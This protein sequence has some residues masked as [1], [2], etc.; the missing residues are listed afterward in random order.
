MYKTIKDIVRLLL[1]RKLFF[2][3]EPFLR[4]LHYLAYIGKN[5]QCNICESKLKTFIP[6]GEDDFICPSCGSIARNRYFWKIFNKKYIKDDLSILDFSPSR[7]LYRAFKKSNNLNYFATDLSGDFIADYQLDITS[8]DLDDNSFDI[9]ICYHILEHI[10]NDILA[11]QE[12]YRILKS[13]GVCFIQT[14]F[15]DEL[16][17][18][19]EIIDPIERKK[20]FGQDDHVRIY[21]IGVLQDRLSKA[22]FQ[23][24]IHTSQNQ[25]NNYFAFPQNETI[26]IC[27][28]V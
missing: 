10:E 28:K 26:L 20:Y 23:I 5:Y 24:E 8:I 2:K 25:P 21:S 6:R 18:N 14:P 11:M 7:V 22:G 3:A 15:S 13:G 12:L 1:P 9:I 4:K 17:E 16:M 19:P 27:S